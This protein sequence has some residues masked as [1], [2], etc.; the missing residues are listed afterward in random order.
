MP[1]I[2]RKKF[3]YKVGPQLR[4]YLKKY[5]RE[6][7]V[8]I[9]YSDLK[10]YKESISHYD[11]KGK[12]T[13]W[14]TCIYAP[15]D[16]DRIYLHL[17]E[18]YALLKVGGDM[19][20]VEHLGVDRIDIC[21][22]GNT[23]PFRIRIIN[24]L[25]DNF[26][27]FYVK[28]ADASRIYGLELE[29]LLSP[30]R[31]SYLVSD[32]SLIEEHIVGIP[33]DEFIKHHIYEG[34]FNGTRLAKEF[35]KFNERCL[36]RLLGDM[37]S[38]NFVV[39]ITPDFDETNYRIRAI[40]FD[41]QSFEGRKNIY[42]PQFY[43][44]NKFFFD[45]VQKFVSK[46]SLQQYQREERMVMIARMRAAKWPLL[47]LLEAM[48]QEPIAPIENVKKLAEELAAYYNSPRILNAKNMGEIVKAS[49]LEA[50]RVRKKN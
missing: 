42:L 13:L 48:G 18:I 20:V 40:D 2:S 19:Q 9:H 50:L 43:K 41:Q 11:K 3:T 28:N 5:G 4:S 47:N 29:H 37:H 25:N 24:R 26:D 31:I 45:N 10:L 7:D 27:Y 22:Y 49:L 33:G 36:I 17:L 8:P 39:Q 1:H 6:T 44:Q 16:Q 46:K 23:L 35:V 38:S 15:E 12:D 34:D 14:E 30:N 32:D 21:L